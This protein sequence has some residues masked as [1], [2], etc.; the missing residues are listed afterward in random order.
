M[1]T[2]SESFI[3]GKNFKQKTFTYKPKTWDEL[4]SLIEKLLHERGDEP[5]FND[6]DISEVESLAAIFSNS[7][8][9][10]VDISKW[11]TS[12]IKNM[13]YMFSG[14]IYFNGDVGNLDVSNVSETF[15]MFKDCVKFEGKGLDKW[16]TKNFENASNMFSRCDILNCDISMWNVKKLKR[17]NSMFAGCKNFTADLGNWNVESLEYA[18][19]MFTNCK[20][21]DAIKLRS[22]SKKL[23]SIFFTLINNR[24][25]MFYNCKTKI[26]FRRN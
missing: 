3:I 11:D 17:C 25:N 18:Q 15:G 7:N 2:F 10:S 19:Y 8:I 5:D 12:H 22:W 16:N 23:P 13:S 1:K 14:C 4:V 24:K 6:I 20:N 21:F 9:K 26:I